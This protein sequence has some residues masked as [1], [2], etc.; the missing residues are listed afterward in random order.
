[1]GFNSKLTSENKTN[2]LNMCKQQGASDDVCS[3]SFI[4]IL[5][6]KLYRRDNTPWTYENIAGSNIDVFTKLMDVLD[7]LS[8]KTLDKW[9]TDQLAINKEEEGKVFSKKRNMRD[10]KLLLAQMNGGGYDGLPVSVYNKWMK[11]QVIG[12]RWTPRDK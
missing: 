11:S 8:E 10:H 12:H 7:M 3:K 6:A 2:F 9:E 5:V 4:Q 1:M